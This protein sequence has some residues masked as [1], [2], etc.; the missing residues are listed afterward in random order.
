MI[1]LTHRI[2]PD[3]RT[4]TILADDAARAELR[5]I[6]DDD[7]DAFGSDATLIDAFDRLI[8]NSELEWIDPDA[9]GDLTDAPILGILGE[10]TKEPG[11]VLVGRWG[12]PPANR[13]QPVVE[14]W[15][16]APYCLRSPLDDLLDKGEAV[17]TA[18]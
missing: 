9:C 16:F 6:R 11:G 3:R 5:A 8:G 15:A 18:P 13:Y 17:F 12:N 14:R 4:L 1:N 2:S 7:P 10:M